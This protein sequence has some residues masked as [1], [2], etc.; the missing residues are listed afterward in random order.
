MVKTTPDVLPL[1]SLTGC[2]IQGETST[3][4]N[5]AV[6][7]DVAVSGFVS[8]SL[9]PRQTP[10]NDNV[11]HISHIR[12]LIAD[13]PNIVRDGLLR[14][15]S[16]QPDMEVVA[17]TSLIERLR[18][19]GP[20]TLRPDV[21]IMDVSASRC[22][23]VRMITDLLRY[24]PEA[25]IIALSL[26]E[27]PE[28]LRELMNAGVVGYVMMQSATEDLLRAV[29]AVAA[30]GFFFDASVTGSVV[31]SFLQGPES[32]SD[33]I[34][35]SLSDR[36]ATVLRLLAQGYSHKEIAAKLTLSIK[37]VETY[38]SRSMEKL[39]LQN[40]VDMVRYAYKSGWLDDF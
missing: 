17:D 29:R 5:E 21:I 6:P 3:M 15:L 27:E 39:K 31:R 33:L 23:G 36:E 2:R 32:R 14:L 25:R 30:G 24:H 40:R 26:Q 4:M 22:S 37:T 34:G 35:T 20:D 11:S 8:P 9:R 7:G 16:A 28:S 10:L 12:V 1:P 18:L 19:L 13:S 38:K